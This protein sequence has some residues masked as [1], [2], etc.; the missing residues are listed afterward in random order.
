MIIVTNMHNDNHNELSPLVRRSVP[1]I[2]T[3]AV[4]AVGTLGAMTAQVSA[5]LWRFAELERGE[6]TAAV[7]LSAEAVGQL[8]GSW[9]AEA[10][11]SSPG[12][13]EVT[14]G[15]VDAEILSAANEAL[16]LGLGTTAVLA[17]IALS[18]AI[19]LFAGRLRWKR[20]A[21]LTTLG[22]AALTV[23]S[24]VSQSFSTTVGEDL[25]LW[26]YYQ[27]DHWTEPGFLAGIDFV[28]VAVGLALVAIGVSLSISARYARDAEGVI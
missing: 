26:L 7:P 8:S 14:V 9:R 4:L 11:I 10:V 27:D 12:Y 15:G 5:A 3:A 21:L 2:T 6:L 17:V 28:P 16:W 23:M 13:A 25:S 20:L 22:G 18:I 1:A 19:A 24:L